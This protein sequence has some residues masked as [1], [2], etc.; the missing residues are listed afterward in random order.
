[1]NNVEFEDIKIKLPEL[2]VWFDDREI[3]LSLSQLRLLMILLS[4]PIDFF[5]YDE[6]ITRLD[7]TSIQGLHQ[8]VLQLRAKLGS[9]YV[10]NLYRCGYAL[11]RESRS[12]K[13][14]ES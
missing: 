14:K 8:L 10:I 7:L 6:L 1:M 9:R 2:R 11:T 3:Y 13:E 5:T 12:Q 4:H